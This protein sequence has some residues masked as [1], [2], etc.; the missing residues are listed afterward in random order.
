MANKEITIKDVAKLAECSP[1]T[2]SRVINNSDHPV[3]KETAEKVEAAIKKLNFSPNRIAQGLKSDRSNIIGVIVHDICDSYF[4]QM[5]K[6][7]E[8][9][10]SGHEYIVN[11]YNTSRSVEKELHAFNLLKANRADAIILAGGALMD[12]KYEQKMH[13]M[14]NQLQNQNTLVLGITPHPFD[15]KNI[16][17]GN[18]RALEVITD[19]VIEYGHR[20]IAYIDGPEKLYTSYLRKKGF[21]KSLEKNDI[22]VDDNLIFKGDFSFNGGRKAALEII[23]KINSITAVVAANDSTALGA[24]WELNHQAIKVPDQISVVGI[25]NLPEAK[26]SYPP[27]T[28]IEIPIYQLGTNIGEYLLNRLNENCN[29]QFKDIKIKLIMR[30]SL[31]RLK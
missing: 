20:K 30:N 3:S 7:I 29:Y 9:F 23:K 8:E 24:M 26:Y 31:K 28:T 10:I 17:L 13:S 25:D 12:K 2:V 18:D 15:I 5:V 6:G 21:K 19:K 11:I 22:A 27:L 4:A 16:I 14:I 1:T